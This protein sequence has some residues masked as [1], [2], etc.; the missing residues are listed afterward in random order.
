MRK[1]LQY[2]VQIAR[3]SN[4][5]L[6]E[7]IALLANGQ[8]EL[9]HRIS[10]IHSA[11]TRFGLKISKIKIGVSELKQVVHFTYLGSAMSQD[12]RCKHDIK[13]TINLANG[14]AAALG[15]IWS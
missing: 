3:I 8:S 15:M 12:T 1:E 13:R 7:D 5:Q 11:S 6:A 2:L 9:K 4:L 10:N 14:V